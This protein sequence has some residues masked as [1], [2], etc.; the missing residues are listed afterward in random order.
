MAA[1]AEPPSKRWTY[2]EYARLDDE[3][4]YEI[5]DGELLMVPAPDL[6]HQDWLGE[7]YTRLRGM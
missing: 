4:R 6:S 7:L 1:L 3:K 2:E 5:I